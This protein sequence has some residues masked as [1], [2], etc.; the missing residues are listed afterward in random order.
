[1]GDRLTSMGLVR[2]ARVGSAVLRCIRT[3]DMV[4]SILAILEA[5]PERWFDEAFQAWLGDAER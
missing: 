2:L 5:E 3:A 4:R 1:M